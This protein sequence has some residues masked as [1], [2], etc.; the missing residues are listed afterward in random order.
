METLLAYVSR[1]ATSA[2][3][4]AFKTL[5]SEAEAVA[6]VTLSSQEEFGHYQC[7]SALRLS[8]LLK[9]N[10]RAVAQQII[11]GLDGSFKAV[12]AKI[13]IAGPGFI[14]ITFTPSFLSEQ[15]GRLLRDPLLGTP[16]PSVRKKMIVEFSSPNIAKELHVGH[17]RSTII[18]DC[19][20]RLF[21]FLGHDVL[22]LNHLGDWGTQ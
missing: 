19:L 1:E 9:A 5:L 8:K 7:N 6:D 18:G 2:V 10:P 13:E 11:D 12:C 21:E 14:N 22:R 16:R 3:I 20:A 4:R 17:L 15:L